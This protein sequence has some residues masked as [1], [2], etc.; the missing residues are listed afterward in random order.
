[1]TTLSCLLAL[2]DEQQQTRVPCHQT[3]RIEAR[4]ELASLFRLRHVAK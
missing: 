3:N 4:K 2:I 1:M